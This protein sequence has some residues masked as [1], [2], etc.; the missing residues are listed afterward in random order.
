MLERRRARCGLPARART[1]NIEIPPVRPLRYNGLSPHGEGGNLHGDRLSETTMRPACSLDPA[2][3]PTA[4]LLCLVAFV[5]FS[6]REPASTQA[7]GTETGPPPLADAV[8]LGAFDP[9]ALASPTTGGPPKPAADVPAVPTTKAPNL[10]AHGPVGP[11]SAYPSI[12][13]TF[14]QPM[15]AFGAKTIMEP[16]DL[17]LVIEPAIAGTLVWASPMR[18]EYEPEEALPDARRWQVTLA[19]RFKSEAGKSIDVD[20]DF[21]FETERPSAHIEIPDSYSEATHWKQP[22]V[23]RGDDDV[24]RAELRRRIRATAKPLAGGKARP[25]PIR[26]G[27]VPKSYNDGDDSPAVWV[28]PVSHWPA[29][30]EITIIVDAKLKGRDGPLTM[31]S[32]ERLSFNTVAGATVKSVRCYSST[33]DDGCDLGPVVVTFDSPVRPSQSST[34]TLEHKIKGTRSQVTHHTGG[35]WWD[36]PK[37]DWYSSIMIWG[38]FQFN[39][40]HTIVVDGVVDVYGQPLVARSEHPIHFVEPPPMLGLTPRDGT[41]QLDGPVDAGITARHLETVRVRVAKLDAQTYVRLA[42]SKNLHKQAWPQDVATHSETI[43]VPHDGKF[44]FTSL[45]LDLARLAKG[46]KGPVLVEVEPLA[47][48]SRAAGRKRPRSVRRLYQLASLGA[49]AVGSAPR[50]FVRVQDIATT[51]PV[52]NIEAE[53]I[54][55]KYAGSAASSDAQGLLALPRGVRDDDWIALNRG[56]ETLVMQLSALEIGVAAEGLEPGERVVSVITSERTAYRPGDSVRIT[57][58]AS[59]LTPYTRAGLRD[60]P[61]GAKVSLKLTDRDGQVVDQRNVVTTAGGKFWAKLETPKSGA[62]G[63]Y[64]VSSEILASTAGEQILVEDF[65]VPEFAV[66]ASVDKPD[67]VVGRSPLVTATAQYYFGGSVPFTTG[68]RTTRC[69]PT[70]A[71]RPPGLDPQWRVGFAKHTEV[72]HQRVRDDTVLSP[73]GPG[74]TSFLAK[75][76]ITYKGGPSRCTTSVSVV[77]ATFQAVGAEANYNIHPSYYLLAKQPSSGT[78]PHRVEIPV[79]AVTFAGK[80]SAG[81]AVNVRLTRRYNARKYEKISGKL[82]ATGWETKTETLPVCSVTTTE[83]GDDPTCDFGDLEFGSYKA[84]VLATRTGY[85]PTVETWFYVSEKSRDWRSWANPKSTELEIGMGPGDPEPGETVSVVVSSPTASG[86]GQLMLLAGGVREVRQFVLEDHVAKVEFKVDDAWVPSA[87]IRALLPVPGK[88]ARLL[89]ASRSVRVGTDHRILQVAVDAPAMA[90]PGEALPIT[91][92]VRDDSGDPIRANVTLWAVDEAVLSLRRFELPDL[93]GT[94]AQPRPPGASVLDSYRYGVRPFVVGTDSYS[95]LYWGPGDWVDRLG[96]GSGYGRGSGAGFSG[97]GKRVPRVRQAKAAT[98]ESRQRFETTPIYIGDAVTDD[99]GEVTLEGRLPDNLTTFRITAIAS[100]KLRGKKTGPTTSVGRFGSSDARTLVSKSLVVRAAAPRGL[101]PG[102]QAEIGLIVDDRSGKGGT[103]TVELS[104]DHPALAIIGKAKVTVVLAAGAQVRVPV[105]VRADKVAATKIHAKATLR[106]KGGARFR[107]ALILPVP[108]EPPATAVERVA[109]YGDLATDAA[110]ALPLA[111]PQDAL[112]SHGGLAV[113]MSSTLLGGLQDS[114]HYLVEYPHG[115]VEQTSSRLLPLAGV[116][117]LAEVFPLGLDDSPGEFIAAG[118]QRLQ[119]MQT[120]SGGFA[121]WPGSDT[122]HPYASAY[123]TWVLGRLVAAGYTVRSATME[124][125]RAYLL[126]VATQ[127]AKPEAPALGQDI[128][129]TTAL[130][131]L[132]EAGMAP[133]DLVDGLYER[134]QRLPLFA[135]ALLM[136]TLANG[137]AAEPGAKGDPRIATLRGEIV[138]FVDLRNDSAR[139]ETDGGHWT[140]YF[141]SDT[142]TSA[143]FMMALLETTPNDPLVPKL[144]RGLMAAQRGGRWA[145]TQENAYAIVAMARYAAVY[146]AETPD[147]EGRIWLGNKALVAQRFAGREMEAKDATVP[148]AKLLGVAAQSDNPTLLLQRAGVGRMYYRVGLEW[149]PKNPSPEASAQGI[150]LTRSI[151]LIDGIVAPGNVPEAGEL[152]AVDLMIETRSDMSFVAIDLPLPSGLEA[153]AMNLGKGRVAMKLPGRRG[154]WVTHQENRADRVTVYVDA[155]SAGEYKTTV[156]LRATAAGDYQWP[157]AT[158]EMMY[159][160]EVYGRS[161][162]GRLTVR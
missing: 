67:V 139:I 85:R 18:L 150:Q 87:Q 51:L 130:H 77:D 94:F 115:C 105:Q 98:D 54:D 23:V 28:R 160:P 6:C 125:A 19:H 137:P 40:D 154:S 13:F 11:T 32:D 145:N 122:P 103:L 30:A 5:L 75:P 149:A 134:H 64:S 25:V 71:Y 81:K 58:W 10:L 80:R 97:R 83:S 109:V 27:R 88:P 148:M 131:V 110:G 161:R 89:Q 124:R 151:R 121:Y 133:A 46:H 36:S 69:S 2:R 31:G 35:Q 111:I 41:L 78:A 152:V 48:L 43:S 156:F 147:F 138:G 128:S 16:A 100:A 44:G 79:R 17:G 158:A 21:A 33:H 112:P 99:N 63:W 26:L 7:P 140:R 50:S 135:K 22:A 104:A 3:R 34:V 108:I 127:W 95:P 29:A 72:T 132:S 118:V 90:G 60:V 102:D 159:Y 113:S 93:V 76:G 82:V 126:T 9:V 55:G 114:V 61:K 144:A 8:P 129:L 116:G 91:V 73:D 120:S 56:T 119:S 96:H 65:R 24:P 52:A 4:L 49:Y 70:Y 39:S 146:E 12:H 45:K 117:P 84:E 92:T 157:A 14:D 38:D 53:V 62:L 106:T 162:S 59:V 20:L 1:K 37:R 74:H 57:G 68:A 136:L 142:R 107:D 101:R 42:T 123:A 143:L 153:V 66:S 86:E 155:L 47:L 15:V 141:D